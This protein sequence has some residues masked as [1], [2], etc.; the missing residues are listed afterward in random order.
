MTGSQERWRLTT[1]LATTLVF[2]VMSALSPA[3]AAAEEPLAEET[4]HTRSATL[5]VLGP[6]AS[7]LAAT[8]GFPSFVLNARYNH[9][10]NDWSGLTIA[11]NVVV[12]RLLTFGYRTAGVKTGYRLAPASTGLEGWFVMPTLNCQDNLFPVELLDLLQRVGFAG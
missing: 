7:V 4:R 6:T 10:L 1:T 2:M 5:N 8:Q 11:P 9:A 12:T 3:S